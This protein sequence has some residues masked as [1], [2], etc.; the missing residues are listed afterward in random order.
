MHNGKQSDTVTL[1]A[2]QEICKLEAFQETAMRC[3]LFAN[4]LL[5]KCI[6]SESAGGEHSKPSYLVYISRSSYQILGGTILK[7]RV[8]LQCYY[9]IAT[10]DD[11]GGGGGNG[12]SEEDGGG[13]EEVGHV[14]KLLQYFMGR[15]YPF[16][17]I[18]LVAH[19]PKVEHLNICSRRTPHVQTD[20]SLCSLSPSSFLENKAA[21][22]ALGL[23]IM[24][25]N[26][27]RGDS[28]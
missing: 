13:D 17:K 6:L 28:A 1:I 7:R 9:A 16:N 21:T 11:Y 10:D 26:H 15:I 4:C 19:N 23:Q 27:R 20:R 5:A 18:F 24:T 3:F 8:R 22:P 14:T 2:V 12:D 25:I